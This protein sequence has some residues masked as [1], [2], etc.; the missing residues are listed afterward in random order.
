MGRRSRKERRNRRENE[1]VGR[2]PINARGESWTDTNRDLLR[3]FVRTGRPEL[4]S[5]VKRNVSDAR[6]TDRNMSARHILQSARRSS[7]QNVSH[8]IVQR[9]T[10]MLS[11]PVTAIGVKKNFKRRF[12]IKY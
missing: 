9:I 1:L 11:S 8:P 3:R 4:L 7:F 10:N 5:R 2:L 6:I 12:R